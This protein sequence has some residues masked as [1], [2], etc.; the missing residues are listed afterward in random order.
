[1]QML[2]GR[3]CLEPFLLIIYMY[4]YMYMYPTGL[5]YVHVYRY[6]PLS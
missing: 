2:F 5:Y 4:M 6:I 1:M 3:V